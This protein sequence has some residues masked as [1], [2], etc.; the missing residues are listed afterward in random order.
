MNVLIEY[1][2]HLFWLQKYCPSHEM[3]GTPRCCCCERIGA[4]A[5]LSSKK[6]GHSQFERKVGDFFKQI[7]LTYGNG[8]RAGNPSCSSI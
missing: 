5:T 4:V 7:T 3:D 8:F 1:R 6:A 2:A